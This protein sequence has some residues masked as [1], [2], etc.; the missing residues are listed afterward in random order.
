MTFNKV[1]Q[2]MKTHQ[3]SAVTE[4]LST[5]G[6]TM[7]GPPASNKP[8]VGEQVKKGVALMFIW[9][10]NWLIK[11][12]Y[13]LFKQVTVIKLVQKSCFFKHVYFLFAVSYTHLTLPTKA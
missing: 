6:K 1:E 3:Q 4:A 10:K 5:S 8:S 13:L 11:H 12:A 9:R 7:R 2:N